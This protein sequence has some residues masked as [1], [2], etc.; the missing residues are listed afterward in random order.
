MLRWTLHMKNEP[1]LVSAGALTVS[2]FAW[3]QNFRTDLIFVCP[4]RAKKIKS[5][6]SLGRMA[7]GAKA[8][9][10]IVN[11]V[12]LIF[13]QAAL[14]SDKAMLRITLLVYRQFIALLRN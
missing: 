4:E 3:A 14:E 1:K 9:V 6:H 5:C 8:I 13:L 7:L 2:S 12:F 11:L 10:R